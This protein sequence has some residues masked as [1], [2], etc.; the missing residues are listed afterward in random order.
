MPTLRFLIRRHQLRICGA[1]IA[2]VLLGPVGHAVAQGADSARTL[3]SS[4]RKFVEDAAQG[5][6]AEV[7]MGQL[8]QQRA[9]HALV[10]AFGQ[11]IMQDHGKAN[12]DLKRVASGKGMQLPATMGRMHQNN[13]D[14]LAKLSGAE[15]DRAYMKHMLDD[16]KKDISEFEKASKSAKDAEVKDFAAR[17]LPTLKSHLQTAQTT[18]DAVK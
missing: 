16:H 4:D 2:A 15:F 1:A 17:T 13:A 10:K 18:Y 5:N 12:D 3:D 7:A 14:R 11:R 8:A 6:L 9:S